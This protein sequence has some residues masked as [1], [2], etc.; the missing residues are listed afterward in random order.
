MPFPSDPPIGGTADH[1]GRFRAITLDR[2][3]RSCPVV[4]DANSQSA[5]SA[6]PQLW[7]S[8]EKIPNDLPWAISTAS[9]TGIWLFL[10]LNPSQEQR[11]VQNPVRGSLSAF[12]WGK[13][14]MSH[15]IAKVQPPI[16]R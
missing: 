10:K 2:F 8:D 14:S 3:P 1:N 9:G 12:F 13:E 15:A 11:D 4:F 7:I 16:F 5:T 6:L